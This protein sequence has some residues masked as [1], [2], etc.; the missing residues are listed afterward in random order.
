MININNQSQ[1]CHSERSEESHSPTE[2]LSGAKNDSTIPIL[3]VNIYY[4][5]GAGKPDKET[6]AGASPALAQ[7]IVFNN[8]TSERRGGYT[9]PLT[10]GGY[11]TA[12]Q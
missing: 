5:P 1:Q 8:R 6:R 12:A 9:T 7:S 10:S 2:I 3:V 4:E 11:A